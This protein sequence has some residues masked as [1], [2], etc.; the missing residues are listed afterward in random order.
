MSASWPLSRPMRR[1]LELACAAARDGEVPVGAVVVRDGTIIGEGRNRTRTD[2]DPTAHA[3][4]VALR[5]AASR[6]GNARLIECDL[7][8]T[9]EPCSMCAGAIAHARIARL[10][11]GAND[12]KGGAIEHG[13]RVFTHPQCLHTPEIFGGIGASESALLLRDFFAERR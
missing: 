3:E 2:S 9:L 1:A 7:H 6:L 12:M 8:V 10:Y 11:Y 4:I 13:P 5:N